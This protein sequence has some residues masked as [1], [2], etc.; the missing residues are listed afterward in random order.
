MLK[1]WKLTS[2]VYENHHSEKIPALKVF[3]QDI[4]KSLLL[5]D[6]ITSEKDIHDASNQSDWKS[7]ALSKFIGEKRPKVLGL[8]LFP[9]VV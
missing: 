8:R 1:A 3:K 2:V 4:V 7:L 5:E 9:N 6:H